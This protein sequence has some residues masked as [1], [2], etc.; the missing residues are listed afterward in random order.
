M[1]LNRYV[2]SASGM[3]R[4]AADTAIMD[5]RVTLNGEIATLGQLVE[6]PM[7]VA[8]DGHSLTLPS[9]FR[10]VAL[11]KPVGYVS[12]REQQG[13]DPIIYALLPPEMINLRLAGRLDRDSS[14]L[15]LLSDD[16]DFILAMSHPSADKL[17]GYQVEL[18]HSPTAAHL[19]E[20]EQ[21]IELEDGPSRMHVRG[22]AGRT[23]TLELEEGRNRQIRRTLGALGYGIKSLHRL[24]IGPYE[25]GDLA[26]GAWRELQ[27]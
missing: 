14:G 26:P 15:I 18:D 10:Y 4:R 16:G 7:M 2:A 24:S 11:H 17:K 21:G 19:A 1:R 12:S 9:T 22:L 5:G 3:S 6:P 27:L 13:S 8:L 23:I 20:L 25:L